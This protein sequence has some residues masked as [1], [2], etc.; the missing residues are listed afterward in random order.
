MA[1]DDSLDPLT[2]IVTLGGFVPS[3]FAILQYVVW[4]FG[5]VMISTAILR[6]QATAKGRNDYTT[7]Q[8]LMH[9]L[10]GGLI[11]VSAELIGSVGKGLF[12]DFESA[13]V[14]MYVARDSGGSLSKVSMAA[15]LA[16]VQFIGAVACI[17]SLNTLNRISIG[18]PRQGDTWASAFWFAFGG[19][20]C[21]FIQQTIGIVSAL[22]GLPLSRFINN[23]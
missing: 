18:K 21:V 9:A 3:A 7:A 11:G 2:F 23:L 22:T 6:Q 15:F 19:L 20:A 5:L 12:G 13:S 17:F 1:G 14:L 10:F 4:L 16:I 8:N